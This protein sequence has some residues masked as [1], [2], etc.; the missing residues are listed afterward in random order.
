MN[1]KTSLSVVLALCATFLFA[2]VPSCAPG[3][4]KPAY[5]GEDGVI[6]G[7][8]GYLFDADIIS[9]FTA[10]NED[11][12]AKKAGALIKISDELR[13]KNCE[14]LFVLVPSKAVVYKDKLPDNVKSGFTEQRRYTQLYSAL[15]GAGARVLDLY[16]DFD[17]K[18]D[19]AQLYHT[20]SDELNDLGGFYLFSAVAEKINGDFGKTVRLSA[21]YDYA[22]ETFE[23]ASYPLTREYRNIT[24]ETVPNKTVSLKEKETLYTDAGY[25]YEN[26]DATAVPVASRTGNF[27]YPRFLLLCGRRSLACRKFF[28][29]V[30]A[31]AVFRLGFTADE[32]VTDRAAPEYAV[33]II[34][35]DEIPSLPSLSGPVESKTEISAA[36]VIKATAYTDRS[37]FVIFGSCEKNSTVYVEGGES[38]VSVFSA[39]GE[40]V[41]EAPVMKTDR[42]K[43]AVYCITNGKKPGEKIEL[44]V[45]YSKAN[46]FKNVVIGKDG[47]LHYQ[48]TIGDYTG[49]TL[50]SEE[51]VSQYVGYLSAKADRIHAV[52]PDTKIIYVVPPNHLTVY[53]ETAPDSLV[54][55]KSENSRLKQLVNAFRDSDKIIFPD[56]TS[57]LLEA[58]KTAPYRLYNKTDTHWNELGAYYAYREIMEIVAK[59]FPAAAPEP[60]ENF[61]VFTK[62]VDGGDMVNFLGIELS[63]VTEEGVYVRSKKELK[64]GISKD[65]SMNFA[66]EWFSDYHEFKINDKKLP[67]MIMY[68]DSFSTN[69]M[70]FLAEKF[71]KSRFYTMWERADEYDLYAEMKPDYL[72]FEFVERSLDGLQ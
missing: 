59:D 37:R 17:G 32:T 40:F 71:S 21:V 38:P 46:G 27:D 15:S 65:Y 12:A 49:E 11:E 26:T 52:S 10:F 56:L 60:L 31:L 30:S 6:K 8:D 57:A 34:N 54:P 33:I 53:P 62:T 25:D 19:G 67:T 1:K 64:S 43:L 58:K 9:D 39:D 5:N 44:P 66:N 16:P 50:W 4:G 35:E 45:K 7:Y 72:I 18:K 36:P 63:A 41:I 68:R 23:D 48:E 29:A 55:M 3:G 24:G 14:T 69:L 42:S 51:T 20:A 28:S 22:I 13:E 61:N 47:H 70:S 2:L